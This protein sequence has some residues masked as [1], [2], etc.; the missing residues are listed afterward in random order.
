MIFGTR[1]DRLWGP[2]SLLYNG[3]RV[4][5]QGVKRP[6]SGV[7]PTASSPEVTEKVDLYT[8]TPLLNIHA[9]FQ[10]EVYLYLHLMYPLQ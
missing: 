10:G 6:G 2:T 1:P 9:L 3:N 8:S 7:Y 5:F 4:S